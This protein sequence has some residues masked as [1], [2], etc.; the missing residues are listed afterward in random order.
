MKKNFFLKISVASLLLMQNPLLAGSPSHKV[1][2]PFS[3]HSLGAHI[4]ADTLAFGAFIPTGLIASSMR[5]SDPDLVNAIKGIFSLLGFCA[6]M[7][8][9]YKTPQW[10]DTYWLNVEKE[11][12]TQQNIISL[13]GRISLGHFLGIILT[14][15][16]IRTEQNYDLTDNMQAESQ[17][18]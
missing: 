2:Q 17:G 18:N 13:M 5:K 7:V 1:P 14:E 4:I 3:L 15:V 16:F 8:A 12:T 10:T 11:R 6:G 9:L